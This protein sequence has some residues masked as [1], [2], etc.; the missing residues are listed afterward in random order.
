MPARGSQPRKSAQ[1]GFR[2]DPATQGTID[3]AYRLQKAGSFEQAELLYGRVLTAE[4]G[5]PF[6]LF[7]LGSMALQRGDAEKAVLLLQQARAQ[8]YREEA[9]LTQLGVAYQALGREQE[10]LEVY[11]AGIHAD[12]RNPKYR[13][14]LAVLLAQQGNPEGALREAQRALELDRTF[15]PAYLNAGFFLQSLG[16]LEEAVR[17]FEQALSLDPGNVS[18]REALVAVRQKVSHERT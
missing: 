11:R 8:G 18:V 16:R 15:V 4:P 9:V 2:K 7:A 6:A 3:A 1:K 13:S 5:N 10:A 14:N 17:H 12:P